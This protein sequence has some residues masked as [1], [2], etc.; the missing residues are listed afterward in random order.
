MAAAWDILP[1]EYGGWTL[2]EINK[3]LQDYLICIEMF[4]AAMAFHFTFTYRDFMKGRI[5]KYI[6]AKADTS[7]D[8]AGQSDYGSDSEEGD[9]GA[10]VNE[11][12][13]FLS[14]LLQ[15]SLPD[16]MVSDF[17]KITTGQKLY[18]AVSHD[19]EMSPVVESL[20]TDMDWGKLPADDVPIDEDISID[21]L[22][23]NDV[24]YDFVSNA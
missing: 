3:G 23:N 8:N 14:A 20:L 6:S 1:D 22:C 2:E 19:I 10:A 5:K 21:R 4:I 9:G 11:R 15:S 18:R 24:L 12:K 17:R 13:P 16:D 7:D